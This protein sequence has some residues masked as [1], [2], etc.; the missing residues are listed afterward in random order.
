[1]AEHPAAGILR[2]Q[3]NSPLFNKFRPY[4]LGMCNT[5]GQRAYYLERQPNR[6]TEQGFGVYA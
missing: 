4:P 3:M 2:K 1:M 6:K 5:K